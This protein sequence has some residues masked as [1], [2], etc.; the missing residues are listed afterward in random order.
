MDIS[1]LPN[2]KQEDYDRL[3]K[4]KKAFDYLKF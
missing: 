3:K 4:Y 1:R 2:S